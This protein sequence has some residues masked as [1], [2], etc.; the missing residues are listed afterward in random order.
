MK[1]S[2]KKRLREILKDRDEMVVAHYRSDDPVARSIAEYIVEGGRTYSFDNRYSARL[3]RSH[4]PGQQDHVHLL[5]KG[6][7]VCV[8]NKD[9]TPSHNSDVNAIP[10]YLRPKLRN[11]GVQIEE[12]HL[13][14]EASDIAML[15]AILRNNIAAVEAVGY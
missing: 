3:D 9:G 8:I 11:I 7:D 1:E 2:T 15:V 4:V 14:V 5:F 10:R 12:A 6:K 13:I